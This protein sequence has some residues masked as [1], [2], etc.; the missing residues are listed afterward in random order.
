MKTAEQRLK[1][2]KA[3]MVNLAHLTQGLT[4][5][6][7]YERRWDSEFI[8]TMEAYAK[9]AT[10]GLK[11]KIEQNQVKIYCDPCENRDCP[12]CDLTAFFG[13]LEKI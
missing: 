13:W 1:E 3:A 5:N 7:E 8:E 9:E 10:E 11:D 12:N 4:R 2:F 6:P